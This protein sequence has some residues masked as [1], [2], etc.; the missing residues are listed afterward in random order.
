MSNKY[1]EELKDI[2]ENFKFRLFKFDGYWFKL[3]I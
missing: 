2:K 3:N 1:K